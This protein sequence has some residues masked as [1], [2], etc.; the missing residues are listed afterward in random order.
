MCGM[1]RESTERVEKL[2]ACVPT[3]VEPPRDSPHTPHLRGRRYFLGL[4]LTGHR[5]RSISLVLAFQIALYGG[6]L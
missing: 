1:L 2:F 5:G 3:V 4:S 6:L